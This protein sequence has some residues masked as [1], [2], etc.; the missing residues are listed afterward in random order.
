MEEA[1]RIL[2]LKEDWGNGQGSGLLRHCGHH[3][4]LMPQLHKATARQG[5]P[6]AQLLHTLLY[7]ALEGP[8]GSGGRARGR[9]EHSPRVTM[10][11]SRACAGLFPRPEGIPLPHPTARVRAS[12]LVFVMGEVKCGAW[13]CRL[14]ARIHCYRAFC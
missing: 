1:P 14:G 9:K 2:M 10:P 6:L 13:S 5:M 8:S 4:A 7:L 12:V 3:R 11:A